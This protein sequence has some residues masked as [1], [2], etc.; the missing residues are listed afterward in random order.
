MYLIAACLPSVRALLVPMFERIKLLSIFSRFRRMED[1]ESKRST[2]GGSDGVFTP[3]DL[4]LAGSS[5]NDLVTCFHADSVPGCDREA[6]LGEL[7]ESERAFQA[8]RAYGIGYI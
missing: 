2:V 1:G 4:E 8:N 7:M 3:V 5:D 6:G